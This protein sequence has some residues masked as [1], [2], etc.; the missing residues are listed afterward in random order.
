MQ[1]RE[2]E[3]LPPH[4]TEVFV[5]LCRALFAAYWQDSRANAR[6][7][8]ANLAWMCMAI[9][10]WLL[11]WRALGRAVLEPRETDTSESCCRSD[12]RSTVLTSPQFHCFNGHTKRSGL[13]KSSLTELGK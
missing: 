3:I 7:L 9:L 2:Q 1:L 11:R 13:T 12:Y 5:S 10:K 8:P 6:L 4:S